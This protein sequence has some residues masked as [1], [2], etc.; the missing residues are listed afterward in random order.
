[1]YVINDYQLVTVT[2]GGYL[3]TDSLGAK[4]PGAKLNHI[5]TTLQQFDKSECSDE[6]LAA[7]A[8]KFQI[9]L[10]ALKKVLIEKLQILKPAFKQKIPLIYIN[11]DDPLITFILQETLENNVSIQV[12]S[13]DTR[14]F[15]EDSMVLFYRQ[16]YS[17]PA[18]KTLYQNL[19]DN[20]YLITAGVLHNLLMIDNIY[21]AG[22]GLPTHFSNLY[23]LMSYLNSNLPATKNNWL[24]FYRELIKEGSDQFPDPQINSCQRAYIAYCLYQFM[25]QFTNLWHTP[26]PLD[27]I[28]CFWQADLTCFTVHSEAAV[29]SPFSE[30]DMKLTLNRLPE[31][32]EVV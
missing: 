28:N 14:S 17:N 7:L 25:S 24:L 31:E 13:E 11:S 12:V 3:I 23:H 10:V 4:I 20:V 1:M 27:Q 16:N 21:F 19:G 26:T 8:Q 15:Q 32:M 29:H 2:S 30:Y 5:L 9:E 18:Y 22:S 6:Q